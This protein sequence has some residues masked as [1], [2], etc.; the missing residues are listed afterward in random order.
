MRSKILSFL[1][2]RKQ[3]TVLD[4]ILGELDA[5]AVSREALTVYLPHQ[6]FI[7]EFVLL[8]DC[9]YSRPQRVN[10]D[11]LGRSKRSGSSPNFYT[12]V[13]TIKRDAFR[14]FMMET[15]DFEH[16]MGF[17]KF[18]SPKFLSTLCSLLNDHCKTPKITNFE[19]SLHRRESSDCSKKCTGTEN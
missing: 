6:S 14:C 15:I 1:E 19:P 13:K 2:K 18:C 10:S 12:T 17:S 5:R 11:G 9:I 3:N 16:S 8:N 4:I 7:S